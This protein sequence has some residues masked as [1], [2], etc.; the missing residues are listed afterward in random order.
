M[1]RVRGS[2][3]VG[4]A[5][6]T[7]SLLWAASALRAEAHERRE[8][9]QT[10][11]A[12]YYLP[13]RDSLRVFSLGFDEAAADLIWLRALVYFGDEF[14][15]EGSAADVFDYA[16]AMLALNPEFEA[17]YRW[18]GIAGLYRPVGVT[19]DEVERAVAIMEEGVERF[20][21]NGQLAWDLGAALAFELPPL[22]EEPADRDEARS[23]A[24]PHLL[25]AVRLG[26]APQ[27]MALANSSML[28]QLGRTEQA[29]RHL[30]EMYGYVDD[31]D[32]RASI[33]ERIAVLREQ[34][35]ADLLVATMN[36]LEDRRQRSFP[37]LPMDLFL[38]VGDRPPVE[39]A[40]PVQRGL[41]EALASP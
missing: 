29:A 2:R 11:E 40:P 10:Y 15:Y 3:T 36:E 35:R 25:R 32:M 7:A 16:E 34:A 39:L 17:V 27:W 38:L 5:L 26:S 31:P 41:A 33:A 12:A 14:V 9:A 23:R 28:T 1:R 22:L 13:P 30:E 8:A 6:L 37:Y 24:M 21:D 19:A 4:V 20:P 18:I